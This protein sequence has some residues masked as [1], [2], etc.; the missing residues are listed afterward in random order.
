MFFLMNRQR[1]PTQTHTVLLGVVSYSSSP[2]KAAQ[3]GESRGQESSKFKSKSQR[4]HEH[5]L[6]SAVHK[7][8]REGRKKNIFFVG[9]NE[10]FLQY[11]HAGQ[12]EC[13]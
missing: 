6:F 9:I 3:D 10:Y 5:Q 1:A 4:V 8:N 11:L 13:S 2:N 12:T 7:E